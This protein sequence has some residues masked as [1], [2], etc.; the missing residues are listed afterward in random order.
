MECKQVERHLRLCLASD[1]TSRILETISPS[2]PLLAEAARDVM[3]QNEFPSASALSYHSHYS[4]IDIGPRGEMVAAL[5]WVLSRDQTVPV[6]VDLPSDAGPPS[7]END[8]FEEKRIVTVLELLKALIADDSHDKMLSALP[9]IAASDG[10]AQVPLD[11]ALSGCY[12]YFNHFVRVV[13]SETIDQGRLWRVLCRGGA[14]IFVGNRHG[15]D[16][17]IPFLRG[18]IL[19]KENI[20]AILVQVKNDERYGDQLNGHLFDTMNPCRLGLCDPEDT[21]QVPVIRIVM[22][23]ASDSPVIQSRPTKAKLSSFTSYDLWFAGR[24]AET[25]KPV[26]SD[27]RGYD[28]ILREL[29]IRH[30]RNPYEVS[31]ALNFT[32]EATFRRMNP[33]AGC[34]KEHYDSYT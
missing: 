22:A 14:L 5:R 33:A 6:Q 30:D 26:G 13:D 8:G 25:Y 32:I 24:T 20:G 31:D 16:F 9:S 3:T 19:K 29:T 2:E 4:G 21:L 34:D 23:L 15:I 17:V 27:A 12:V 28:E 10:E 11:D 18:H 7:F 1:T